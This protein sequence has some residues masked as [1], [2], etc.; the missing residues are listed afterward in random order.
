M[1]AGA[2]ELLAALTVS[3]CMCAAEV[4]SSPVCDVA[5]GT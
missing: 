4:D 1:H 3:E 2:V 5:A